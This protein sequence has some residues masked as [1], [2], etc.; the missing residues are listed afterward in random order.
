[1]LLILFAIEEY[2][3]KIKNKKIMEYSK[4]FNYLSKNNISIVG[5]KGASLGEMTQAGISVPNGF[6]ILTNAF[7]KVLRENNLTKKINL[8]LKK[9][10]IEKFETIEKVSQNIRTL[11]LNLKTPSDI[12]KEINNEFKKLNVKFVAIRS[13]ATAEDGI[14]NT[15]AGQLDTFL[16][17]TKKDL[18]KNII[19]CWASLFTPRAIFYRFEKKLDKKHISVAVVIQKMIKS[20]K[21]GIAFS[22]HPV[23]QDRNQILIEAGFG[24][25]EAIVSG[26]ITPDSYVVDKQGFSILDI[27]INEQAKVLYKK[28]KGGNEWK[29]LGKK[30]K[31]QVLDEK[32]I[33]ELA[34][35]VEKIEN[36]YGIPQDIEWVMEDGKIYITQSRPITTLKN[37]KQAI[38]KKVTKTT[39]TSISKGDIKRK[40]Y[41]H[42]MQ[43]R[44]VASFESSFGILW[45]TKDLEGLVLYD[46]RKRQTFISKRK[47][48]KTLDE[49]NLLYSDKKFLHK[50]K[51]SL[52]KNFD[53]SQEKIK[54]IETTDLTKDNLISFLDYLDAF[55]HFY[56]YTDFFYTDKYF[57]THKLSKK[58]IKDFE[59]I[60]LT[61]RNYINKAIYTK[62]SL[63]N[64][65]LKQ[66]SK[67]FNIKYTDISEYTMPEIIDLFNEKQI[68][69]KLIKEREKAHVLYADEHKK[70]HILHGNEAIEFIKNF[71]NTTKND[72]TKLN[73][74]IASPGTAEG[75]ARVIH[76]SVDNF[77][78]IVKI[79]KETKKGEIL[80]TD[81]TIPEIIEA[82]KKVKA[83]VTNQGG[84]M[85]HAAIVSREL[86]IP[87]IVGV[88]SATEKI[89]TG[90]LIKVNANQGTI[91]IIGKLK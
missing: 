37:K 9:V 53:K 42:F 24:L 63:V 32:E 46:G 45:S 28:S 77:D 74:Q 43:H 13:S 89:K 49:G 18:L 78:S 12:K 68:D 19:K 57:E 83:I 1:M 38:G 10:N 80:V 73:G 31:E 66:I 75:K 27:N 33:L 23:T 62:N 47:M 41:Q 14:N 25:G 11:I 69:N 50:V 82:C 20:E 70:I 22:V 91:K 8:E 60:K 71:T 7:E 39:Q 64:R 61:G 72:T 30:G 2:L 16:N 90:D 65:L 21:S 56:R 67:K 5:G 58:F 54:E 76:I 15:W 52:K 34:K 85:S 40:N 48:L 17:T 3:N 6:V 81:S 87:C 79:R 4:T 88:E 55:D 35:L 29:N 51:N 59:E 86:K 84:M 26:Q 36:H 44:G